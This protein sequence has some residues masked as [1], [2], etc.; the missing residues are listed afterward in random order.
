MYFDVLLVSNKLQNHPGNMAHF[1][2]EEAPPP[3]RIDMASSD[4]HERETSHVGGQL[5]AIPETGNRLQP[6]ADDQTVNE[7]VTNDPQCT[8]CLQVRLGVQYDDFRFL[9]F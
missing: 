6:R 8:P 2:I 3:H 4:S 5:S 7:G 1:E 9:N